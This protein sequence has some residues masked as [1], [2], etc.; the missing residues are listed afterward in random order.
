MNKEFYTLN[1]KRSAKELCEP[2]AEKEFRIL[3]FGGSLGARNLNLAVL[4]LM[5]NYVCHN[6][7]VII[8]H[9]CGAREYEYIRSLFCQAGLDRYSNIHLWEYIYDM[10]SKMARADLVISRSGAS[11]LAELAAAG[12]ASVLIPSPNVTGDQQRKNARAL[13]DKNAA[14]VIE[15]GDAESVLSDTVRALIE[16]RAQ[17][18]LR[19]MQNNVRAFAMEACDDRIYESVCE[20]I[21]RKKEV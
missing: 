17:P 19:E 13:A 18:S 10:P 16:G 4:S 5:K 7:E 2:E 12:K 9:A 15:D 14:A 11:T 1:A 21:G 3:S 6:K 20:L 8:E